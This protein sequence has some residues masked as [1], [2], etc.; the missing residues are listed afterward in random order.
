MVK[1]LW[2]LA[3]S[4]MGA[5]GMIFQKKGIQ[6]MDLRKNKQ[7]GALNSF[8]IWIAGILIAYVL[9]A[10]PN[11]IASNALPP[12][13]ITAMAGWE[14]VVIVFLSRVF[15]KERIYKSDIF[16]AFLIVCSTVVIGLRTSPSEYLRDHLLWKILL[17]LLPSIFLI[18]LLFKNL[19]SK[20]KATFLSV[21]AGCMGGV[22]LVYFNILVRT[23]FA[24]GIKGIQ[25]SILILYLLSAGFGLIT[26]QSS[27]RI[28]E[29]TVVA[30]IRLSLY[31]VYPVFC[32]MLLF[33]S[34]MDALQ[35][36][37]T[38]A[39]IYSCYGIFKKR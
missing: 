29:M 30:S 7:K 6:W 31:I 2:A 22:A 5:I 10:L 39:I 11:S 26:E 17:F 38:G 15:L 27:Y 9:S 37:A 13:I 20:L 16:Y 8:L 4:S 34:G 35:F 33:K 12:H 19:T 21:F 25:I 23:L 32:S 14:I 1:V 3:G 28:G 24:N 18:P 36:I